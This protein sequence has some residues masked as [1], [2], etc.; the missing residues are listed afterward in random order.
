[1]KNLV[2]RRYYINGTYKHP[3]KMP[4]GAQLLFVE[5]DKWNYYVHALVD[6][7]TN[8]KEEYYFKIYSVGPTFETKIQNDGYSYLGSVSTSF[9]DVNPVIHVFYSKSE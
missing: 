3:I 9:G 2:I 8:Q 4:K 6:S 1:M 5:A 7:N